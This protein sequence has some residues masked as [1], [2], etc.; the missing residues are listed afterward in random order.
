MDTHTRPPAE[1]HAKD[2]AL[3][4]EGGG[5]RNSYTA[6]CIHELV[7]KNI[8]FGWVGGVSAGASHL[9]NFL[10]RDADRS[11]EAFVEFGAH[12]DT[13]GLRSMV[14]GNGFFNAEYIYEV[15]GNH[16]SDLPFDYQTFA[17]DRTP[18][19]ISAFRADTGDTV[20]WGREDVS[21]MPSLMR[22]VRA[23]STLPGLMPMP[24]IDD[25]P[26]VDGA[27]G[28]SGGI[29]TEAAESDGFT[30]FLVLCTR[31][32][33][34]YRKPP[35]SPRLIRRWFRGYP[36]VAEAV[37][38]RHERYNAARDHLKALEREG[39]ALIFYPTNMRVENRERNLKKLQQ[40]YEDGRKQ[41]HDEWPQWMEFLGN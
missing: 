11:R 28:T 32:R 15:A 17:A 3:V 41:T 26:Y 18:F 37:I 2:V 21:S 23:S 1:L 13:G 8:H 34:F 4:I 20:Y 12:P 29:V 38:T 9:V 31:G 33:D 40:S 30:R 22:K 5:M 27:L 24:F 25:V 10:S 6:A 39:R 19:R 7:A 36:H 35:R 14:R 16:D